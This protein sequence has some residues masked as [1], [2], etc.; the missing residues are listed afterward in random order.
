MRSSE[1]LYHYMF[2]IYSLHK[3]LHQILSPN[4]LSNLQGGTFN[5]LTNLEE[6]DVSSNF[7]MEVPADALRDLVK[8][9]TLVLHDNLIQVGKVLL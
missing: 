4:R 8:L 6:L 5:G 7:L 3:K 1:V 2:A 9:R